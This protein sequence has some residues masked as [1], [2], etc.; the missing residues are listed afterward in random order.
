MQ[1][2]LQLRIASI[3]E[4]LI[5]S[6]IGFGFPLLA[7]IRNFAHSKQCELCSANANDNEIISS[8]DA[9]NIL[10]SDGFRLA[11]AFSAGVILSVALLHL[12]NDAIATIGL[13][14]GYNCKK[15]FAN[16][17]FLDVFVNALLFIGSSTSRAALRRD[18]FNTRT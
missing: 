5:V 16:E 3:F 15:L 13:V 7:S 18:C 11:K 6:F 9:G 4:I 10:E 1:L 14:H 12:L 8:L 17:P 2:A